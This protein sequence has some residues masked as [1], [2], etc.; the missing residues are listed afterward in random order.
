MDEVTIN[1]PARLHLGFVDLNGNLGRRFGS[2]GV[3]ITGIETCLTISTSPNV[4]AAENVH[5]QARA[6]AAADCICAHLR[7]KDRPSLQLKSVIPPH[8]GLGSGTQLALAVGRGIATLVQNAISTRE[9]AALTGRGARSGIGIGVFDS[10]GFVVDAGRGEYTDVPPQLVRVDF[11]SDWPIIVL[12]DSRFVGISGSEEKN[13]FKKL[14]PMCDELAGS[15]CRH[16][17]LGV[18][19]AVMERDFASF[20]NS[21]GFIQE[22]I[23]DYFAPFQ[24]GQRFTSHS[25]GNI[26][27]A[28]KREWTQ[29]VI[30]QSSWG[31][32]GFVVC[33]NDELVA[34]IE[35]AYRTGGLGEPADQTVSL[36][37]HRARNSGA[38]VKCGSH[39]P[40]S[41]A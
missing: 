27:R 5:E 26:A 31:P 34:E 37:V 19:P 16:T 29:V 20:A 41:V 39:K 8:A 1:A 15:L 6:E 11:P 23:G 28:I 33:P 24:G 4:A 18:I 17:L 22:A 9:I 21:L 36:S 2:L 32:T 10:G 40:M 25:I 14:A 12:S 7:L 38:V 13:A 30:G 3:A 35:N